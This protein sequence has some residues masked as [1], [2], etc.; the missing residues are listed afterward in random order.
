MVIYFA[1][2]FYLEPCFLFKLSSGDIQ[3]KKIFNPIYLYSSNMFSRV[4]LLQ[5]IITEFE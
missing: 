4:I 3:I 2:C 5:L 1:N